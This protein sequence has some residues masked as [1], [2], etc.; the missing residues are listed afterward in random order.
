MF[1]DTFSLDVANI[2]VFTTAAMVV[3]C[4][5]ILL[6][7]SVISLLLTFLAVVP[8]ASPSSVGRVVYVASLFT[9]TVVFEASVAFCSL[10]SDWSCSV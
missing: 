7:L 6:P 5:T 4:E 2:P 8:S 1:E 3:F 9:S 10:D